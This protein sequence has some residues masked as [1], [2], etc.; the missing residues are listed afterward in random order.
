MV[1]DI[2]DIISSAAR[3]PSRLAANQ[4]DQTRTNLNVYLLG[5][6]LATSKTTTKLT[7]HMMIIIMDDLPWIQIILD[8]PRLNSS[9]I[10]NDPAPLGDHSKRDITQSRA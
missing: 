9:Y 10:K 4:S 5:Y 1:D 3:V 2:D 7:R 8:T 6:S